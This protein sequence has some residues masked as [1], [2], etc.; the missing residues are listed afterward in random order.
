[1]CMIE[2]LLYHS[3]LYNFIYPNIGNKFILNQIV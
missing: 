2:L 1:M 3:T